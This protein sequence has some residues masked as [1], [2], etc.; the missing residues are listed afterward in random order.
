MVTAPA[1]RILIV[2]DEKRIAR[3][4]ELTLLHEEYDAEIRYDGLSGLKS[5]SEREPDL[6]LLD[7]M[8]P[9]I[10]GLEVCRR[11]REFSSVP[12]L[13]LTAKGETEDKVAGLDIGANDYITKPFE[14]DELLARIRA[15]LR[16]SALAEETP[17]WRIHDLCINLPRHT[18]KRGNIPISLTKR[19]F[20]LLT[21]LAKNE[22]IVLTR[23]QILDRV[24]GIDYE[25]EANVV[26][27]Y[28]RYLR[29]KIDE[30]FEPKL[31]HTVRGFGYVLKDGPD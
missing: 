31:I 8:L 21:Y 12:I 13:M 30:P 9:E 5:A 24:W 15:A 22:G 26:D 1:K 11:V 27:V 19:E 6:I 14:I 17:E 29:G 23:E 10:D 3:L 2:E 16:S 20:N 4:I 25:G 7:L 28:I 18:V